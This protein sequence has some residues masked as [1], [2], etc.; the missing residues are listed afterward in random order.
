MASVIRAN[1]V[2]APARWRINA[3]FGR[4]RLERNTNL[5]HTWQVKERRHVNEMVAVEGAVGVHA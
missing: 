4:D 5:L 3:G 1:V 2:N